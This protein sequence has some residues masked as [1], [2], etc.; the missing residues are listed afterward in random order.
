MKKSFAFLAVISLALIYLLS[1][2]EYKSPTTTIGLVLPAQHKAL[3]EI[4]EG[5]SDTLLAIKPNIVIKVQNAQG[6]SLLQKTIIEQFVQ[7]KADIIVPVGL[8]ATQMCAHIVKDIPIVCLAAKIP[9]EERPSN[10]TGVNDELESSKLLE[11][12]KTTFYPKHIT[13]IHSTSEKIFPEVELIKK[14]CESDGI[15]LQALMIQNQ[16]ELY[17]IS[18]NINPDCELILVLKDHMVV[19]GMSIL[20]Q[21]AQKLKI[22]LMASDDGSVKQGAPFAVAVSEYDIGVYGAQLAQKVLAGQSPSEVPF[23]TIQK[24]HLFVN[25][26]ACKATGVSLSKLEANAKKHSLSIIT[27]E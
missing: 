6:E 1:N 17:P 22:P 11:F 23:E 12:A 24:L 15:N 8:S 13:L 27:V 3:D 9:T 26:E 7:Q 2:R 25:Q 14:L 19:S 10:L 20:S 16:S 4:A 21:I 5:F 18:K